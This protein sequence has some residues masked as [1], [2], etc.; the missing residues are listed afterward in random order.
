MLDGLAVRTIVGETCACDEPTAP[1]IPAVVLD[2]FGGTGT[3]ALVAR[4]LGR[5]AVHVDLSRD[6]CRLAQ[7]RLTD[8]G[9]TAR[10]LGVD[11]PEPVSEDQLSM[12]DL[13]GE[14]TA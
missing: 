8:P 3:T 13:L 1:T 14:A 4:A 2:P 9:E 12:L 10:A 5:R 11:K 7:W 6:Y